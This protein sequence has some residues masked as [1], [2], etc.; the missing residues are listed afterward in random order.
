ML[1]LVTFGLMSSCH[2]ARA[3]TPTTSHDNEVTEKPS[4]GEQANL[5]PACNNWAC[6]AG[7]DTQFV[8]VC[9]QIFQPSA[10]Y[11]AV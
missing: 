2:G 9:M 5:T 11:A 1:I 6:F 7:S 8:F 3:A 4:A 10:G